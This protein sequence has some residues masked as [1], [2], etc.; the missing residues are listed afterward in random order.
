MIFN[1]TQEL[2]VFTGTVN[3]KHHNGE[4]WKITLKSGFQW[5]FVLERC[6]Q[7]R[8]CFIKTECLF[9]ILSGHL[10]GFRVKNLS[11]SVRVIDCA[12]PG[13]LCHISLIRCRDNK[14]IRK[15]NLPFS[16]YLLVIERSSMPQTHLGSMRMAKWFFESTGLKEIAKHFN[17]WR[18]WK[19]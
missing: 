1:N 15:N 4:Q 12:R 19:S 9:L 14:E 3:F 7:Y 2:S 11:S 10:G 13:K 18:K 5:L 17:R 16:F 8:S 6:L